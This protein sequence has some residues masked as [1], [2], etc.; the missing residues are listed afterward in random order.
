MKNKELERLLNYT[1]GAVLM[2]WA[3]T[4]LAT[5]VAMLIYQPVEA[6]GFTIL[7]FSIYLCFLNVRLC[8]W[9]ARRVYEREELEED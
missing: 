2:S 8:K 4:L 9:H 3:T 6:I 7:A 5:V 1:E